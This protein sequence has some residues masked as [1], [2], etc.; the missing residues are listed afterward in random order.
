MLRHV[1]VPP[2][3]DDE[4]GLGLVDHGAV[5][6]KGP[7][8][9]P[10]RA[11]GGQVGIRIRHAHDVNVQIAQHLQVVGVVRRVP[12]VDFGNGNAPRNRHATSQMCAGTGPYHAS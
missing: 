8:A 3:R 7:T 11:V 4:V 12:M 1:D 6:G 2:E 9:V 5:V 10:A